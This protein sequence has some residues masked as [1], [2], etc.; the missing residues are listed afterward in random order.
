MS[1]Y[2][3]IA[4]VTATLQRLL[5]GALQVDI[6]GVRVT[7][8]RPDTSG[9]GTPEVGVNIFLYQVVPNPAWRNTDLRNRRPKGELGKQAQAGIDLSYLL[10]FYGNEGELEP[11]RLL[12]S[13]LRTLVDQPILTPEMIRE[14]VTNSAFNFL[15]G[16]TL[17][18]QTDR[19]T[20][21]PAP[22]NTEEL[23]KIWSVFFQ[24]PYA[25]SFAYQGSTVLIEGEKAGKRSLPL[26]S[27]QFFVTPTQ[28]LIEQVTSENGVNQP[29][30][31]S[32]SLTITGKHL[33]S[34]HP[35]VPARIRIGEA[36]VTPQAVSD[37]Q[38][39]LNLA[40]LPES[41]GRSLRAGVQ[42]LQVMHPIPGNTSADPALTAADLERVV[43]SNVVPVILNPVILSANPDEIANDGDD[44]HTGTVRVQTDVTLGSNQRLFLLLNE[45]V[46]RNPAAYVFGIRRST[47][48][49]SAVF[50][51]YGVQSGIYLV[52]I[53]VD[54][55]ESM[56][57]FDEEPDSPTFD[58][59]IAPA[60]EIR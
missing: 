46:P 33:R 7:T 14:T 15:A 47:E 52:R 40:A 1:N 27:R 32:S 29:I 48:G 22:M 30:T 6:P 19:V 54:N 8:V 26:R 51:I 43:G 45:L 57:T 20:L 24:T 37:T 31:L 50:P 58:Q 49:D 12:G 55:A 28:P 16:S 3:A 39:T 59:Y 38:I 13:T 18:E 17:A 56:P 25:L 23:S 4:T 44:L 5:Q 41:E 53:H 9:S 42:G 11:Q 60:V 36:E 2:L 10:T 35:R 21:V 34:N